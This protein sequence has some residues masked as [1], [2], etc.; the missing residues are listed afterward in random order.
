MNS[1]LVH[2]VARRAFKTRLA[3][4]DITEEFCKLICCGRLTVIKA[5]VLFTSQTCADKHMPSSHNAVEKK[6]KKTKPGARRNAHLRSQ[7]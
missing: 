4:G 6:K 5:I 7:I 1:P 3:S 2:W